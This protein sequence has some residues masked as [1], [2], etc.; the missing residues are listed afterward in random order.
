M[1]RS[2]NQNRIL[3]PASQ[4]LGRRFSAVRRTAVGDPKDTS[5]RA[6][7]FSSH[8]LIHEPMKRFNPSA[9]LASPGQFRASD[10]PRG[11]VGPGSFAFV[12]VFIAHQTLGRRR[13]CRVQT[14]PGLNA[15][16]LIGRENVFIVFEML[17]LPPPLIQ[18]KD[19]TGFLRKLRI[20][21]KNP[22]AMTP[23]ANRI[24]RQPTPNSRSTDLCHQP[25]VDSGARNVIARKT[26]QG[27]IELGGQFAG[28]SFD[29]HP[30]LRGEMW[31]D[32]HFALDRPARWHA[33]QSNAVSISRRFGARYRAV[34]QSRNWNNPGLRE[35]QSLRER[36]LGK[37]PCTFERGIPTLL[38]RYR[39][40]RFR[41]DL[42]A[43]YSP[44]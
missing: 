3:M 39:S 29:L 42:F 28:Q 4:P 11:Q 15:C 8:R 17:A 6:I 32:A 40:T 27:Q 25:F 2:R 18:V 23:R 5:R 35:E 33:P 22:T 43:A 12:L 1:H 14:C 24:C 38:A 19:R 41:M 44:P 13:R 30:H 9:R 21:R 37:A 10:V 26:R 7:W 34:P 36:L 16:F 31:A 20:T